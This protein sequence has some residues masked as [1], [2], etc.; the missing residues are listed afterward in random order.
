MREYFELPLSV[1]FWLPDALFFRLC[2]DY[3][4]AALAEDERRD[5]DYQARLYSRDYLNLNLDPREY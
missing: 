5:K 2:E 4:T 1:L 3:L